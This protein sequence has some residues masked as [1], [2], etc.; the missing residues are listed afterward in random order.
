MLGNP[1]RLLSADCRYRGLPNVMRRFLTGLK[2]K[3]TAP[4]GL[5]LDYHA[6]LLAGLFCAIYAAIVG[7]VRGVSTEM[8][9]GRTL[10]LLVL[11]FGVAGAVVGGVVVGRPDFGP[12]KRTA[13][14]RGFVAAIP[15]YATGGLL[16]LP[17]SR[18]FSVL[19][20]LSVAAAGIV[21]P[22]IG[23]FM[24]RL[25]R[26]RDTDEAVADPGVE[27]AWL[28]GE[29]LGSW[30]PLLL[31]I[32]ILASLGVGMRALPEEVTGSSPRSPVP[33][34]SSEIGR[35]LP[36]LRDS[37]DAD[38]ANP[39]ARFRLGGALFSLGQ[40]DAAVQQLQRA[41]ELD[42]SSVS[43][44]IALGRAAFFVGTPDLSARAY[45]NAIR[46]DPAALDPTGFDRVI[47]DAALSNESQGGFVEP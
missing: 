45:W 32:A 2:R 41:V 3:T 40:F 39:S 10:G 36:E 30:T 23:I 7:S 4:E 8:L 31:S 22:P 17:V 11:I 28:K 15:V 14:V 38:T 21:G 24:Y 19:P 18:W 5:L 43:F 26:R 12:S 13:I 1:V 20:L 25:H 42:S 33:L 34:T 27:L 46:L 6:G 16:F 35:L 47:L 37:V 44:W 9:T 29:M